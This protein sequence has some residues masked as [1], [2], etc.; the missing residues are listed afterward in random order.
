MK[1]VTPGEKGKS[2]LSQ[3]A[4]RTEHVKNGA[5]QNKNTPEDRKEKY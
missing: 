4:P 1:V 2:N 3:M 5:Q